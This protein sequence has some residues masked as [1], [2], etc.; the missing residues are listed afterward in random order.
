MGD[1]EVKMRL[2]YVLRVDGDNIYGLLCYSF[3]GKGPKYQFETER[4]GYIPIVPYERSAGS[5]TDSYNLSY[6]VLF[7]EGRNF[8]EN[9]HLCLDLK[10]IS[11]DSPISIS[12]G[13]MFALSKSVLK[14]LIKEHSDTRSGLIDYEDEVPRKLEEE[15]HAEMDACMEARRRFRID[16]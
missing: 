14:K 1:M 7:G 16:G 13:K 10:R 15:I 6:N 11:F 5:V 12:D 2:M 9:S 4:D 8:K 3:G